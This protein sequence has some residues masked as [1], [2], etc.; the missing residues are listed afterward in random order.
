MILTRKTFSER[1]IIN[2][3]FLFPF[4]SGKTV[5]VSWTSEELRILN[6][7]LVKY[8]ESTFTGVT[9]YTKIMQH[10]PSKTIRD[11]GQK[12]KSLTRIEPQDPVR[13]DAN[14]FSSL[15]TI[16]QKRKLEESDTQYSAKRSRE[17]MS[18]FN[19]EAAQF[20]DQEMEV[21]RVLEETERIVQ[22]IRENL[23]KEDTQ[24]N[25][26]LMTRF[27]QLIQGVLTRI[28]AMPGVMSQLPPLPVKFNTYFV[29]TQGPLKL[30]SSAQN[31]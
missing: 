5:D 21:N 31:S 27:S 22:T 2:L 10:L 28:S 18:D 8:P 25:A 20:A 24:P 1:S 14:I 4:D 13:Y 15:L 19:S 12:V 23:V 7:S 16:H 30:P 3:V 11:I 29:P 26:E 9:R 17:G 6:E